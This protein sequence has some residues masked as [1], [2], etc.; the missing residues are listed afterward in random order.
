MVKFIHLIGFFLI[1]LSASAQKPFY[2]LDQEAKLN[3]H[4]FFF[5]LNN[6]LDAH[7]LTSPYINKKK[8]NDNEIKYFILYN[9]LSLKNLTIIDGEAEDLTLIV[10]IYE[11]G[12]FDQKVPAPYSYKKKKIKGRQLIIDIVSGT[13]KLLVFRGWIDL[14]KMK[15][16]D[17][18]KL[19][20]R[21][22]CLILSNFKIDPVLVD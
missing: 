4:N 21:A 19:Y 13:T 12:A 7:D 3:T 14:D 22:I 10:N 5:I 9:E 1:Y 17:H 16:T 8:L 2:F 6:P 18:Y 15:T 11:G 20:Q